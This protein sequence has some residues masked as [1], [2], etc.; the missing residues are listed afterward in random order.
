MRVVK[1]PSSP[2]ILVA[3][4]AVAAELELHGLAERLDREPDPDRPPMREAKI[5]RW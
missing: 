3:S 4:E 5:P 2:R 1:V